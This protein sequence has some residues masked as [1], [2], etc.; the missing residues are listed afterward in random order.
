[1]TILSTAGRES[2][3]RARQTESELRNPFE[4]VTINGQGMNIRLALII[5]LVTIGTLAAQ[6]KFE[7]ASVKI[8]DRC[9]MQNTI[10]PGMIALNGDPLNV[11]LMEAFNAKM[12][13]IV[14]PSWLD[15]D[16]FTIDAK[17]PAGSTRDQVPAMLQA[18]LAERFGL[19]AHK[20][21]RPMPGYVLVV[22]K[23]GPKL[24]TTDLNS[25][26]AI[27]HAGQVRFLSTMSSAGIKGSMTMALL[28][29][30]LSVRVK[31]PVEDLTGLQG[32]YDVD[33]SW[34]LD[35]AF[36]RP[37]AYAI[38]HAETHPNGELPPAP[39]ADLFM[40]IRETLGLRLESRK[41]QVEV[42]VIDH[43]ERVPSEN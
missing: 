43:I 7:A 25:A 22:D 24:K 39:A 17:M 9:S 34:A 29:H 40:A 16:C 35:P 4:R 30:L 11:V 13:Q 15:A 19:T 42:I 33:I 36:E 3:S 28:A 8:T 32:K 5:A 2:V 12:D 31:G 27:Q 1:M 18:L 23:N 6:S 37:D 10:D 20:E 26:D 38:S 21:G 14:G 41:E